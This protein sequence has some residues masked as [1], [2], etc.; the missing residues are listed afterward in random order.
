MNRLRH[1]VRRYL[2]EPRP[3]ML[4]LQSP[5]SFSIGWRH[6]RLVWQS[7][8]RALIWQYVVCRPSG[9]LLVTGRTLVRLR[10]SE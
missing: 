9:S 1:I 6:R 7:H 2:I 8:S 3:V 10:C 5:W 4:R